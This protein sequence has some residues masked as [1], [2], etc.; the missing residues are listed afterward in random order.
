MTRPRKNLIASPVFLAMIIV[1]LLFFVVFRPWPLLATPS[2]ESCLECH[3][4]PNLVNSRGQ[5]LAVPPAHLKESVHASLACVDCHI[6]EANY[7]ETPHFPAYLPVQCASCH[8]EIVANFN[9][10]PH[11][12]ATAKGRIDTPSCLNCHGRWKAPHAIL[13]LARGRTEDAC[14]RC[15]PEQNARYNSGVHAPARLPAGE[16]PRCTTCHPSHGQEKLSKAAALSS[17]CEECHPETRARLARGGH[18][19]GPDSTVSCASCHDHHA[20]RKAEEVGEASQSCL[21][22]HQGYREK[23]IASVHGQEVALRGMNCHSCH[24]SHQGVSNPESETFGCGHCHAEEEAEY[25]QSAHRLARLQGSRI[26]ASCADCHGSHQIQAG[27]FPASPVNQQQIPKTC[28]KCHT[29]QTVITSDYIRL[30]ISLPSYTASVHGAGWPAEKPAAVCTDCHGTHHLQAAGIA[31]SSINKQNLATTCGQCHQQVAAQY[32][33]SVHAHALAHGISDSPSCT[34]CHNEHLIFPVNDPR[35]AVNH[36][37]QASRTCARCHEDPAMAARYGLP[38]DVVQ[39][40]RDSY[41]GWAIRRG[42]KTVAVCVDCHNSH[43]IGAK[44]DPTSSI[45]HA[46]VVLTCARCHPNA[47]ATFAASYTHAS[48]HSQRGIPDLIR[49]C[50]LWLIALVL[51][52]M[53]LHNQVIIMLHRVKEH[54]RHHQRQPAV[55]RMNSNEIVQHLILALTFTILGIT[56]FALRFPEVWWVRVLTYLGMSEPIRAEIHRFNA[57]TMLLASLYHLGY[58]LLTARGRMQFCAM[59]PRWS[60][61]SEARANLA[62]YLGWRQERVVFARYDYTQK[63]EYWALIWGT[64]VMSVT[65]LVLWFPALATNHLPA[66]AIRVSEMIHFY[67]AILAVGAIII[68]HLFFVIFL[69]RTYPMSWI[70]ITG[71]MEREEWLHHHGREAEVSGEPEALPPIK[72][73]N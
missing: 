28:G 18:R 3:A 73:K 29:N 33:N 30:P 25:R 48:A 7:E 6:Q 53:I 59:L 34:N 46:N 62:Y 4:D 22:C 57:G 38:R 31:T 72:P 41:H 12:L 58:L 63:L 70:W 67:E 11:G 50:Y 52:G 19:L 24:R 13:P 16:G 39:S 26:A 10:S 44:A 40:Y 2:S 61:L 71:R 27:R 17:R 43:E 35:S 20:T 5:S 42:G 66:W 23:L 1:I 21:R 9:S 60:D 47:N 49:Q 55:L 54:F 36:E 64:L 14:Q 45:H 15:H 56:G 68:W 65:G 69:P 8:P 51:G 32:N 37:N